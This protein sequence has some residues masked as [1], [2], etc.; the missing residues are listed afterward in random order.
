MP[1]PGPV[2]SLTGPGFAP[3][4]GVGALT[5]V[6]ALLLARAA[7]TSPLGHGF[8][9]KRLSI[10]AL[11]YA[12]PGRVRS[13]RR[14]SVL[15]TEQKLEAAMAEEIRAEM[16]A[17]V[18]KVVAKPGDEVGDS[19]P[20]VILESMKMEIPVH[21]EDGGVVAELHVA[22]GQVVQEGDLIATID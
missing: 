13:A 10:D 8:L 21:S 11:G 6:G 1:K 15:S 9:L 17:N 19:D 12:S 2:R 22:E 7:L 3:G 18:W 4:S 5:V 20:I 16:V 14:S